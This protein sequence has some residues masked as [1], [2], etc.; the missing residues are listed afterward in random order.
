MHGCERLWTYTSNLQN[1][2][3]FSMLLL[4]A[5]CGAVSSSNSTPSPT[6]TPNPSP[7]LTSV[8]PT[9]ALAGSPS[10]MMTVNGSGFVQ[11]SIVQWNQGNRTPTFVSSTQLQVTLTPADLA[12]GEIVQIVVVNPVPG[13]GTSTAATFTINTPATQMTVISPS[14]LTTTAGASTVTIT[15]TGFL[16]SSTVTW[17]G[18]AR[19]PTYVS[20]TQ[21]NV[22]LLASDLAAIGSAQISVT[23]PSPGGGTTTPTQIAIVY[24]VPVISSLNVVLAPVG[25]GPPVLTVTSIGFVSSSEVHVSGAARATTYVHSSILTAVLTAGGV[26]GPAPPPPPPF[27]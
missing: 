20:A 11:S 13:G 8:T 25:G 23:N 19:N 17:N 5:G 21:L 6:P 12:L 1:A 9:S 10:L 22:A 7:S 14:P 3:L 2:L 24:P 15:G 26:V 4:L 27:T 18:T 16:S